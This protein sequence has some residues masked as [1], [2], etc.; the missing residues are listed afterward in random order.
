MSNFPYGINVTMDDHAK[1]QG[2]AHWC[3]VSPNANKLWIRC[4]GES[5]VYDVDTMYSTYMDALRA[6]D[7]DKPLLD[8]NHIPKTVKLLVVD[9]VN[10]ERTMYLEVDNLKS[11]LWGAALDRYEFLAVIKDRTNFIIEIRGADIEKI[12]KQIIDPLMWG[13]KNFYER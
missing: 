10:P 13:N 12:E 11:F 6:V 5:V 1:R 8:E 2:L 7:K 9:K 4:D 3:C